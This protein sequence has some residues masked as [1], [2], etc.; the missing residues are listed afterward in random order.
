MMK[1]AS[2]LLGR[3]PLKKALSPPKK[4]FGKAWK[5]FFSK[6]GFQKK[7]VVLLIFV[8]LPIPITEVFG[9]E[10]DEGSKRFIPL[11][12]FIEGNRKTTERTILREAGLT[13][14]DAVMGTINAQ[15]IQR[16]LLNTHL[17][18]SVS[19][20]VEESSTEIVVRIKVKERFTPVPVPIFYTQKEET[21]GGL[22]L[23]EPNFL[24][25]MKVVV[26]GA[27]VSTRGEKYQL[28]YMDDSL[29]GSRWT[30]FFRALY[31][32]NILRRYDPDDEI[33]SY[34]QAFT[35]IVLMVGYK[36]TDRLIPSIGVAYRRQQTE[37][38]DGYPEP[39]ADLLS[40]PFMVNLRYDATNYEDYYDKGFKMFMLIDQASPLLGS[41]R[42][43]THIVANCDYVYP[44]K[45]GIIFRLAGE[46]GEADGEED[47]LTYYRLG[48]AMGS[49][50]LPTRGVWVPRYGSFSAGA[51]EPIFRHKW[52]VLTTTQFAD[53]M[54][55]TENEPVRTYSAGGIGIRV[56]LKNIAMPA[57]G[58]DGA[59]SAF[60]GDFKLSAFLGKSF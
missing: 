11:H 15:E 4:F 1:F 37:S 30:L 59:F 23:L 18:S 34:F 32:E 39:P 41:Q 45:G 33:Y 16:R 35:N 42:T 24:G 49:R 25:A 52:G 14:K 10:T 44:L 8:L 13:A 28:N 48:G 19:V 22:F 53:F 31:G 51:E 2:L 46:W 5:P 58:V 7:F 50:G 3:K 12:V 57:L 9:N 17:F 60:T 43:F 38:V 20:T 29:L 26:V 40:H 56:Y 55:T 21:G 36:I 54:L 47:I 27:I 6:K